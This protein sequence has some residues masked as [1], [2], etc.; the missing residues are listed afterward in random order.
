MA[1][2][3][4]AD[5][6]LENYADDTARGL[7]TGST[8]KLALNATLFKTSVCTSLPSLFSCNRLW[9]DVAA[10]SDFN[11]LT[12]STPTIT[13]DSSGNV[14]TAWGYAPGS[15]GNVVVVRMAYMW[16]VVGMP[17][18]TLGNVSATVHQLSANSVLR[19]EAYQ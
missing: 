12:T 15:Q 9:V 13:V 3:Y 6:V 4:F 1:I 18:G 14:G 16:P 8:Q 10:Y 5:A 11:N 19:T 7:M 2:L 17:M